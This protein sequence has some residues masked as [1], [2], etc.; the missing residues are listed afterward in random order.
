MRD[1]TPL[2]SSD[3]QDWGTPPEFIEW[4]ENEFNMKLDLDVCAHE[5]NHKIDRFFTIEDDALSQEWNS[6]NAW[7]N[8]PFGRELPKFIEKAI[9]EVFVFN[10]CKTIW[11]LVPARTCTKW[12][13]D[14]VVRNAS[15]IYFIRGRLNFDFE[16]AVKRANAPFPSMLV[17]MTCYEDISEEWGPLMSTL[18]VPKKA[19]GF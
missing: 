8:P 13:H 3:K 15:R 7:M 18:N 14:L 9:E 6:E 11:I 1:L 17:Q 10:N 5:G 2:M 19:R 12:F 16:R 4:I